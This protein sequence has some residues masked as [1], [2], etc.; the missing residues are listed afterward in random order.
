MSDVEN[1]DVMLGSYSRSDK[2]GFKA[3]MNSIW[4]Q[5]QAGLKETLI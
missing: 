2:K 3:V 1:V 5:S 4:I